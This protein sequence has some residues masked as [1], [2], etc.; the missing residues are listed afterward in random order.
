MMKVQ[1]QRGPL[2][3]EEG[4]QRVLATEVEVTL[5]KFSIRQEK[6]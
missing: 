3:G 5:L 1:V 2:A 6:I 4:E